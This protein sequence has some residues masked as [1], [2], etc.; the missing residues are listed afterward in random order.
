MS[1]ANKQH[2][3]TVGKTKSREEN[4]QIEKTKALQAGRQM[5][6][7]NNK[8]RS[9]GLQQR[10][11]QEGNR[12]HVNST[13]PVS[14]IIS[15]QNFMH[16]QQVWINNQLKDHIKKYKKETSLGEEKPTYRGPKEYIPFYLNISLQLI[17]FLFPCVI[18]LPVV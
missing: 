17:L 2:T 13:I 16:Q 1:D 6:K 3:R 4:R 12:F 10:T 7:G 15:I 11:E 9:F 18:A 14:K 5:C 8:V